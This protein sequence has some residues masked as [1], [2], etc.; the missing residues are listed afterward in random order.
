MAPPCII[1]A[2]GER[3]SRAALRPVECTLLLGGLSASLKY[4][5]L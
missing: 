1:L 3:H 4:F 2:N 5:V